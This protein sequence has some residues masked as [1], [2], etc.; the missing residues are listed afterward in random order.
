[1]NEFLIGIKLL[2]WA[3]IR[4]FGKKYVVYFK[5]NI[6]DPLKYISTQNNSSKKVTIPI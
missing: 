3:N 4:D 2:F 1:M 6:I 5:E